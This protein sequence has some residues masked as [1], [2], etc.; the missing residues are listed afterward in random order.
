MSKTA[1]ALLFKFV[2][3]FIFAVVAFMLVGR[4]TFG[5]VFVVAI[6]GAALNYLAGDLYV[7]PK[8]GNITASV[9]DGILGAVLAF[10]VDLVSGAFTTSFISLITFAV[11]IAVGEYFFH[12]YLKRSEEVAP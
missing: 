2:M 10:L 9:G 4:N 1:W 6:L 8:W 5:W 3:T 12:Q 11:L 7:L